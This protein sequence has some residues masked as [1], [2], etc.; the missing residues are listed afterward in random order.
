MIYLNYLLYTNYTENNY[1]FRVED[2]YVV[3]RSIT[4]YV[5][6]E[7]SDSFIPLRNTDSCYLR[8]ETINKDT[9]VLPD[10]GYFYGIDNDVFFNYKQNKATT[11]D[12]VEN[13]K[14]KKYSIP[15]VH[16]I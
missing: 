2:K 12:I 15:E 5:Y 9:K 7:E 16:Y 1:S 11:Y 10:W 3:K 14:S 8:Y 4:K 13:F 6:P